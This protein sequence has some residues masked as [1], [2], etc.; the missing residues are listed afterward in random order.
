M[1]DIDQFMTVFDDLLEGVIIDRHTA[2]HALL[3]TFLD[4]P[5]FRDAL[6][7][8]IGNEFY[9]TIRDK[10]HYDPGRGARQPLLAFDPWLAARAAHR[11]AIAHGTAF[12]SRTERFPFRL[13]GSKG[14]RA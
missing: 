4:K 1:S 13:L 2:N 7:R 10:A 6:T 8:T 3:T 5:D 11:R 12:D 14:A 9:K